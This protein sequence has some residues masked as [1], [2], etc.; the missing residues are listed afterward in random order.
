MLRYLTAGES[1]GPQLT[2][3]V[4]GVPAGLTLR[5][6]EIDHDLRRRQGG[7]GRG[8]RMKIEADRVRIVSGVRH[9]RT[10]G[11]PI[12]L[13][14]ENK[15]WRNWEAI[16]SPEPLEATAQAELDSE[17]ALGEPR[18]E[19]PRREITRPRP[20]HADLAGAQK[21]AQ[22]DAR[23]VL[24]R[25]SARATA[26]QVAVGAVCKRL[27]AEFGM[28]VISHVVNLGGIPADA[29]GLSYETI[30]ERAEASSVRVADP[31]VERAMMELI[32]ACKR[33][34]DTVGGI[35]E[36]IVTGVPVGLGNV[37]NWDEKLDGMIGRAIMSMQAI[38]GVEIGGGFRAAVR[39]GSEVHDAIYFSDDPGEMPPGHGPTGGF[40]R[41]TNNAG[42]LE[43]GMTN[44]EPIVVRVAKKPISTL[45]RPIPSVDLA[46]RQPADSSKERSDVCALPAAAVIGEALVAYAVAWA[47]LEKFGGDSLAEV[48]R[49]YEGYVRSLSARAPA[50][51]RP[52]GQT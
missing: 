32:D 10:L 24:E 20:G 36:V 51:P 48:R 52:A 45:M 50:E 6:K 16:M 25:A 28:R 8:G 38:K 49:N 47:F 34:G 31:A 23:N 15:D 41:R 4:S 33:E 35:F 13:I 17:P 19:G 14:L 18:G 2:A 26:A 3:I 37:M 11:S 21:F 39:R 1:H 5:A 9:G 29:A 30:A 42:G 40:Y 22:T 12:T 44:G 7:Y 43:G 46:T 27:L